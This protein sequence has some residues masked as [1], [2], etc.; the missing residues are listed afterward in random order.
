M[1]NRAGR[2]YYYEDLLKGDKGRVRK[3]EIYFFIII[4]FC[5]NVF[6]LLLT[7]YFDRVVE[8]N[9]GKGSSPL[10]P[11]YDVI[12]C[13]KCKKE[14]KKQ[15]EDIYEQFSQSNP[16]F[17]GLQIIGCSKT[18]K[19]SNNSKVKTLE[20]LKPL[21]M[22]ITKGELM[23]LLGHNGAG[24]TTLLNILCGNM[25]PTSGYA[26][27]DNELLVSDKSDDSVNSFPHNELDYVLST[28]YYGMN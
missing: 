13:F 27:L 28:T 14:R 20:A 23:T 21:Y 18:Y 26:T 6:Y 5:D 8:S 24:K 25:N 2:Q 9:T 19:L 11:F 10:F 4:L 22:N 15:K 3:I 7:C 1:V 17:E 12:K 16:N